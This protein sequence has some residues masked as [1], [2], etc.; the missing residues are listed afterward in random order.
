MTSV[1]VTLGEQRRSAV[2]FHDLST[3]FTHLPASARLLPQDSRAASAKSPCLLHQVF[4][5]HWNFPINM[6]TCFFKKENLLIPHPLLAP[7]SFLCFIFK[8][9]F[10]EL[11]VLP[12]SSS[13]PFCLEPAPNLPCCSTLQMTSTA[14]SS[15]NSVFFFLDMIGSIVD[16]GSRPL[17]NVL[18]LVFRAFLLP[19]WPRKVPTSSYLLT[20]SW[21]PHPNVKPPTPLGRWGLSF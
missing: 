21:R 3:S 15:V 2:A 10:Q 17:W 13:F 14:K 11:S 8:R 18:Q 9:T 5:L 7:A 12:V 16:N 20:L 4:S 1:L 19:F 6:Q